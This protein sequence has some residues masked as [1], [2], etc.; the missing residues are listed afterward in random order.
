MAVLL[1]ILLAVLLLAVLSVLLL[2]ILLLSVLLLSVLLLVRLLSILLSVLLL[3]VAILLLVGHVV[4]GLQD[5][6]K[7]H[8][9]L[10]LAGHSIAILVNNPHSGIGLL[11]I[12]AIW[13]ASHGKDI[14]EEEVKLIGVEST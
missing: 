2:T 7:C 12:D 11:L 14:V 5:L 6:L 1:T 9:E 4:L 3:S 13:T 8:K 10:R